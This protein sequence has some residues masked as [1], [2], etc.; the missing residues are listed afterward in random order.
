MFKVGDYI[1]VR[2]RRLFNFNN[3]DIVYIITAIRQNEYTITELT[4]SPISNRS[5]SNL[6]LAC[7]A[8]PCSHFNIKE[9]RLKKIK[10]IFND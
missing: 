9:E 5:I 2:N 7:D 4:I 10:E 8:L 1:N 6:V 3:K